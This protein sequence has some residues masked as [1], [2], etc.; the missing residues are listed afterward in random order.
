MWLLDFLFPSGDDFVGVTP[1]KFQRSVQTDD[2]S[3]GPRAVHMILKHYGVAPAYSETCKKLRAT[4]DEGTTVKAM[5]QFLRKRGLRVRY[6]PK[7]NTDVLWA[8]LDRD[9]VALVHLDGD[10]FGVV[11]GLD[12]KYVYLADPSIIRLAGRKMAR[13]KFLRRWSCWALLVSE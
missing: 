1:R 2:W 9:A 12:S 10:H 4:P 3:C 7:M 5:I 11:H 6:Q 13:R 8:A